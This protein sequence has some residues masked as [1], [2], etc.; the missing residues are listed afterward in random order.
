MLIFSAS[1][2][3]GPVAEMFPEGGGYA[4]FLYGHVVD[5]FYFPM[6]D[7]IMPEWVPVIGGDRFQFFKP[8]FNMADSAISVGVIS[9]L[10]FHRK[11]LRTGTTKDEVEGDSTSGESTENTGGVDA[12]VATNVATPVV[13]SVQGDS[14]SDPDGVSGSLEEE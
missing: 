7:M 12:A 1:S 2:Y 6:I 8:V 14:A 4:K 13:S 3:H 5:M 11:F 10:L 9:M